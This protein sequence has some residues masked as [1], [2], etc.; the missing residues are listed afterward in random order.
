M[1]HLTN[2]AQIFK[3]DLLG[4]WTATE[5]DFEVFEPGPINV[6]T[7]WDFVPSLN[8]GPLGGCGAT[9]VDGDIGLGTEAAQIFLSQG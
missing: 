6:K 2:F 1:F 9:E 7:L 5:V 4:G 8:S 3:S